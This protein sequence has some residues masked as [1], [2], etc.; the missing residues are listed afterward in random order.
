MTSDY[1]TILL[2]G[3]ILIL[4]ISFVTW[5]LFAQQNIPPGPWG[6]PV[7]GYLPF[8]G[9]K[10]EL[11]LAKLGKKYGNIFSLRLG[12]RLVVV[13]NDYTAIKEALIKQGNVFFVRPSGIAIG[14]ND[15]EKGLAMDQT[16]DRYLQHR[17]FLIS[18]LRD[19]GM[20]KRNLEPTINDEIKKWLSFIGK[21]NGE[22]MNPQ[23]TL[24]LSTLNVISAMLL[25][26]R[27]DYDNPVL[28][29]LLN[30]SG[31]FV[32]I[33]GPTALRQYFPYLK[34]LPFTNVIT[35]QKTLEKIKQEYDIFHMELVK[36]HQKD[37]TGE[38]IRDYIDAYLQHRKNLI[39]KDGSDGIF[40][41]EYLVGTLKVMFIGGA[42][43][44]ASTLRWGMLYLTTN[45]SIQ[46]RVQAE[47]DA[48]IGSER[49]PSMT[50]Q[51]EMHYTRATL[52]EIARFGSI[53]PLGLVHSNT[54]ETTVLGYKIPK[55]SYIIP[56]LWAAHYDEN[57]WEDVDSFKPERFLDRNG[58]VIKCEHLIP[59]SAGK[60]SCVGESLGKMELFLF[61]TSLFQRFTLQPENYDPRHFKHLSG[62]ARVPDAFTIRAIQRHNFKM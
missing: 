17:R 50:D 19:F 41:L 10:P 62:I 8:L 32:E 11:T 29:F 42:E 44:V 43:T 31:R 15:D 21:F 53:T 35:H 57:L 39:E 37:Q 56:N 40:D 6:L 33:S 45:P 5:K 26:K 2:K 55:G 30:M 54:E 9:D 25:G 38:D 28:E 24:S 13:L 60:R 12:Y 59:F 36:K 14:V 48:V 51:A 52:M 34:Y 3:I 27:F 47:I 1:L 46:A 49:A 61:F 7:V 20:G 58:K 16:T 22:P 18:T 23:H 4:I